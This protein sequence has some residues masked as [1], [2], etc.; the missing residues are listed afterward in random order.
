MLYYQK[1]PR[2]DFKPIQQIDKMDAGDDTLVIHTV[3]IANDPIMLIKKSSIKSQCS[4]SDYISKRGWILIGYGLLIS[5]V[6]IGVSYFVSKAQR[7]NTDVAENLKKRIVFIGLISSIAFSFLVVARWWYYVDAYSINL[8]FWDQWDFYDAFFEKKNL[9]ELFRWQHGPHYQGFGFIIAKAVALLSGW[10]T[11]TEAFVIGGAVCLAMVAALGLRSLL[12][13]R[14]RWTDAAIPLIFLTPIQYELFAGTPNLSHGS[15]PLL[16]LML[17]VLVWAAWRRPTRYAAILTLNFLLI[18]T[19]FGVFIGIITPCLFGAEALHAHRARD[20]K[21]LW[22]ALTC[23][24]GSLLSAWSFFVGYRFVPAVEGFQFPIGEWWHYPQFMAL[25]LANFCGIKGVTVF[26]YI[27]G[28]FLMFLMGVLTLVHAD[29]ALRP[30]V[31]TPESS[32]DAIIAVLTAFSLIFCANTAIGRISLGLPAAQSSRYITYLIPGFFGIYLWLIALP[33]GT[34]R[35]FL[36]MVAVVGLIAASF[37]LREADRNTLNWYAEGKTRWKAT[38]LQTEDIETATHAA[39]FPIYPAPERTGLKQKLEYLKKEK[40]NLYLDAP[41][42]HFN[43][44]KDYS[45]Q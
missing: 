20:E 14:L 13:P 2:R 25:I 24:V 31:T 35:Q 43:Q 22:L 26:S 11:R 5:L 45:Q 30:R 33:Q 29:R 37:P 16:L 34:M 10:N 7:L 8:L 28:F 32:S 23:V 6:L 4:W 21:G 41:S 38:Y 19:G 3:K 36:L 27:I 40:L 9:W 15:V 1:L 18:Y 12:G 42:P 17:Y 39:N 44:E